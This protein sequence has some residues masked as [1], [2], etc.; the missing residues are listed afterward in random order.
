M[1]STDLA[2]PIERQ[3]PLS[4]LSSSFGTSS[5]SWD[6]SSSLCHN[7]AKPSYNIPHPFPLA[8]SRNNGNGRKYSSYALIQDIFLIYIRASKIKTQ[9]PLPQL[10]LAFIAFLS[11]KHKA[12][13]VKHELLCDS[14]LPHRVDSNPP[15]VRTSSA[16]KDIEENSTQF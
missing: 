7:T 11:F 4:S 12:M 10:Y 3:N 2:L 5:L 16:K 13:N 1:F 15:S 8:S 14:P 6:P 9:A